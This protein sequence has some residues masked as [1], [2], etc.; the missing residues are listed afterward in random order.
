MVDLPYLYESNETLSSN[1]IL[2]ILP[3]IFGFNRINIELFDELSILTGYKTFGLNYFYQITNSSVDLDP[4]TQFQ[5]AIKL[6]QEF[7][8]EDFIE[9]FNN[10]VN[11]LKNKFTNLTEIVVCGFCFGGRLALLAAT[12]ANVNKIVSFY[13]AGVHKPDFYA[14]Q[15]VGQV[16]ENGPRY[17]KFQEFLCFYGGEDQSISF[18]ERE[19]TS[20]ILLTKSKSFSE[21][22]Y[23]N[24]GHAF[25]NKGRSN[26]APEV[27]NDAVSNLVSF[28]NK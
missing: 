11:F 14:N 21:I 7:K 10:S 25:F 3:D 1:K 12:N 24:V 20:K 13:G 2:L 27:Y 9:I 18:Q 8:G 5:E 16:L 6:M 19:A 26:F 23:P 15:S 17:L 4:E 22:V 28:L